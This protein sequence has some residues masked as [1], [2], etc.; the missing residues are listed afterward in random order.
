MKGAILLAAVVALPASAQLMGVAQVK[1]FVDVNVVGGRLS[2]D[3]SMQYYNPFGYPTEVYMEGTHA[4]G[5]LSQ[6]QWG[7][8]TGAYSGTRTATGVAGRCYTASNFGIGYPAGVD[9]PAVR[10][11]NYAADYCVP[12]STAGGGGDQPPTTTSD[13]D[14]P[15]C[16]PNNSP[17]LIDFANGDYALTGADAPVWFDINAT[18]TPERIGWTAAGVQ[19]AFLARDLNRNLVIDSGAELFGTATRMISGGLAPNGFAALREFDANGDGAIDARDGIWN[20]LL[21]WTDV[22]HDGMSQIAELKT[23]ETSEL[24]SIG[25]SY[26]ATNRSDSYGNLFRYESLVRLRTHGAAERA[27]PVYDVFFVNARTR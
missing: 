24:V 13:C 21:L 20:E 1:G 6:L 23:A 3:S 25:L 4:I 15:P 12:T 9:N 11:E 22:D 14:V 2:S 8:T 26:H 16:T 10:S 17:I 27:K 19:V 7:V 5:T 18:G